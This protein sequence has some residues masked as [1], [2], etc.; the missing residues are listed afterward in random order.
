MKSAILTFLMVSILMGQ[1]VIDISVKGISDGRT[2]SRQRDKQEAIMDAKRQACE[3]AGLKIESK[4]I[5]ENFQT[6]YDYIETRA[7]V[8]L[9]PGYQIIDIGYVADGT[10]Q[11]VLS[12]K[13]GLTNELEHSNQFLSIFG[14]EVDVNVTRSE[15]INLLGEPDHSDAD[16][17]QWKSWQLV[18]IFENDNPE[19]NVVCF[20][21]SKT[22]E[23]L[24]KVN[25]PGKFF[26]IKM[27]DDVSKVF[28]LWGYPYSTETNF[29]RYTDGLCDKT[30]YYRI[31]DFWIYVRYYIEDY[32]NQSSKAGQIYQIE[33]DKRESDKNLT[34]MNAEYCKNK[35]RYEK[36]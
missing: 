10:Y 8:I 31:D 19:S 13:I 29:G 36:K 16:R 32:K 24:G 22:L 11:V 4:T 34:K 30:L 14:Q 35:E 7:E 28:E 9:L 17:V 15:L 26:G 3:K 23:Y 20:R 12:G 5:V 33:G 2:H 18:I 27:G 1:E 21:K 25:F 6:T